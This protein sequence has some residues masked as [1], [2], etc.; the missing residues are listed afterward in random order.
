MYALSPNKGIVAHR[1]AGDILHT[2]IQM[3]CDSEWI[4][5]IDFQMAKKQLIL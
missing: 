5:S 2:Y 4:D 1:E 3:N